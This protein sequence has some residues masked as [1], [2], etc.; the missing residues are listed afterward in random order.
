MAS[1]VIECGS[2]DE[3]G[4]RRLK[5]SWSVTFEHFDTDDEF[6]A[7]SVSRSRSWADDQYEHA[8]TDDE[9]FFPSEEVYKEKTQVRMQQ[10]TPSSGSTEIS[11]DSPRELPAK[12][13]TS[14][15]DEPSATTSA[16][17]GQTHDSAQGALHDHRLERHVNSNASRQPPR[18]LPMLW[19]LR[20]V[21]E[22][23]RNALLYGVLQP[24]QRRM[25]GASYLRILDWSHPDDES[26]G[27]FDDSDWLSDSEGSDDDD[28]IDMEVLAKIDLNIDCPITEDDEVV[29][30]SI[31]L[32]ECPG[33]DR[34]A[35]IVAKCGHKFHAECLETWLKRHDQCPNCRCTVSNL[36]PACK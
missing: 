35:R 5:D 14:S 15:D 2:L 30:C 13:D 6:F 36:H 29:T 18:D 7:D 31:C 34:S 19:D 21:R 8:D 23:P 22:I 3:F 24:H 33:V 32:D 9:F 4:Y 12:P 25:Y 26:D 27:T 1:P 11:G 10:A 16:Q 28:Y 17:V 20:H